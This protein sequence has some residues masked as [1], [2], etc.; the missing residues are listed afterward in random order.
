M[1]SQSNLPCPSCLH[2][3]RHTIWSYIIQNFETSYFP[4]FDPNVF[5]FS[6]FLELT[7]PSCQRFISFPIPVFMTTGSLVQPKKAQLDVAL[8]NR[9]HRPYLPVTLAD[10]RSCC[11]FH[12]ET[13]IKLQVQDSTVSLLNT[14]K[15]TENHRFQARLSCLAFVLSRYR[16]PGP[17]NCSSLLILSVSFV[18]KFQLTY[19]PISPLRLSLDPEETQERPRGPRYGQKFSL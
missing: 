17:I 6:Y 8:A 15:Q 10:V 2:L 1:R 13:S 14:N 12:Q 7:S 11:R 19:G 4:A 9:C 18:R 16:Q 3:S 5:Y